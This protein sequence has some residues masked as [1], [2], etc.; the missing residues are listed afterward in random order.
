MK[1]W[2]VDH[3]V[4]GAGTAG[5]AVAGGLAEAGNRS[6]LVLEA[7]HG[8]R[9]LL[10]R[11]P[12]GTK[13]LFGRPRH[14]WQHASR[15]DPSLSEVSYSIIKNSGKW[16]PAMQNGKKVRSYKKQALVFKLEG[17]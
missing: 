16:I 17:K 2:I 13:W 6:V 11:V 12:A 14:D 9:D 7:G 5:C 1:D 15:P 10:T 4:I 3:L 8:G